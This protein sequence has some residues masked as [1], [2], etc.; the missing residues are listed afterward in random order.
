MLEDRIKA[1]KAMNEIIFATGDEDWFEPWLMCGIPDG[2]TEEDYED[3]ASDDENYH[4]VEDEFIRLM[5]M[6]HKAKAI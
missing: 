5:K 4:E 1:L 6:I 2:A 3:I